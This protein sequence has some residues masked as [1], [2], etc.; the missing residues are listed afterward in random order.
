MTR[1]GTASVLVGGAAGYPLRH[2]GRT[3][4][5]GAG[6]VDAE[7]RSWSTAFGGTTTPIRLVRLPQAV[8]GAR[9]RIAFLA[10]TLMAGNELRGGTSILGTI[11][12][13]LLGR[14]RHHGDAS[15]RCSTDDA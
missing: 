6:T 15:P 2:P 5:P 9:L 12:S 3:S 1:V 11:G 7:Q 14:K 8:S 13:S 10:S 4:V